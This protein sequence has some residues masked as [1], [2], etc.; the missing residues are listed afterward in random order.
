MTCRV[1]GGHRDRFT[2]GLAW[3]PGEVH[4][5]L[6]AAEED[7]RYADS[8]AQ[9]DATELARAERFRFERDRVR[10]VLGHGFAR[11][12]LGRYLDLEPAA[13]AFSWSRFGK[14][15]VD[16]GYGITFSVSR[17]D[18]RVAV[19]V[20]DGGAV[21]VDIERRR[22]IHDAMAIAQA[23]FAPAEIESLASLPPSER[24]DTFLALWTRKE[25]FVKA[26]GR[27]LSIPLDSF[28]ALDGLNR[29]YGRI[30]GRQGTLPYCS[31]QFEDPA[32]YVGAVTTAGARASI[33][34]IE[35]ADV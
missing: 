15:Q 17:D 30:M 32:G 3:A 29:G 19:A 11:R 9:L 2:S 26:L 34:R 21:G 10:F 7:W 18:D 23:H 13:V 16:P 6:A 4:L 5:W 27:G 14:P 31:V 24:T 35:C 28:V 1:A 22:P 33:R 12:V 20:A 8:L 25:S